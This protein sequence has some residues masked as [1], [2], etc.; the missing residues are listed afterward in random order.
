MKDRIAKVS[1][2]L[3]VIAVPSADVAPRDANFDICFAANGR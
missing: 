2:S 3:Y 1:L